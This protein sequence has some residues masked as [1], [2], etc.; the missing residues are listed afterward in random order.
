MFIYFIFSIQEPIN[1]IQTNMGNE[2]ATIFKIN[3]IILLP[4]II[5][6]VF[7]LFK[8]DVKLSMLVSIIAASTI[9]MIFQQY[10]PIEVLKFIVLGFRLD[11]PSPLQNILKGGG[12]ISMWQASFVIFI[13]C[14]LSGI[15]N[16]TNMLKN[17]DRYQ[18]AIDLE[19]TGVVLSALIPW[20]IAAF[21]PTM[22]MGVGSTGF[23]PYAFYLYLIPLTR[24]LH[25]R[26]LEIKNNKFSTNGYDY[27]KNI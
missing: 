9:A 8:I 19:N 4:A 12:I 5:I 22:T 11:S 15:F 10:K 6:L 14:A 1:F 18:L 21:V 20:N 13:S 2:I 26:I 23:I 25:L 3:W 24:I 16:G 27:K 17:I 7:S